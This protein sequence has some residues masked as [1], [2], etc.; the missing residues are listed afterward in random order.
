MTNAIKD[1]NGIPVIMGASNAD[2]VTMAP[3]FV[4]PTTHALEIDD[5]TTGSD[6]S[7]N[8]AERD[9]NQITTTMGVSNSDGSTPTVPYID[10]SAKK[11]LVNSN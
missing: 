1:N 7:G 9:D 2:G 8:I 3:F 4:H 6:L 11:I 5:N 10:P